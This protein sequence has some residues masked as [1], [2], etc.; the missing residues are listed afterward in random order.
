MRR[1]IVH[2]GKFYPPHPGG[3]E[4]HVQILASGLSG[5][6]H[7]QVIAAGEAMSTKVELLD[8]AT[9]TRL[10]TFGVV[11]SLPLTPTLPLQLMKLDPALLHVHVPNPGAAF[12]VAIAR[13]RG[14]L[15]VTHHADTLGRRLLKKLT[16][17]YVTNMMKRA[18]RI[19]VTSHRYLESSE[20][21]A[22]FRSKCTV[23]PLGM[24]YP[25]PPASPHSFDPAVLTRFD[26]PL[27]L[28]V[29]RLVPYKGY[30]GLL[31]AM[32]AVN[33]TLLLIGT[34]P[35]ERDLKSAARNLGVCGKV[36]FL[37]W[38]DDL[39]PY[40]RASSLFVL[41]SITRAEAFGMVQLEAMAVGLPVVNTDIDSGVPEVSLDGITGITVPPADSAAL[42]RAINLLLESPGL[43]QR[44]GAAAR[45][46]AF[47][48]FA[49][50]LMV[51][52]T[53]ELYDE[54][55]STRMQDSL[56]ADAM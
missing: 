41:P 13:Y 8:G 34:G 30:I 32:Q 2:I 4:S 28:S 29:G 49:A 5:F 19:V 9:I 6:F 33:A 24:N 46:R 45:A 25:E 27:I 10:P 43:R 44:M 7:V 21:L 52:R 53:M 1:T 22:P 26:S 3:I 36:K 23:I 14:P 55:L 11:A 51:R 56:A 48:E 31:R 15:V 12:A 50:G 35:L 47:S 42:A 38:I 16:N 17:P 40:Y 54:V 37:G 18:D 20:E 39:Q